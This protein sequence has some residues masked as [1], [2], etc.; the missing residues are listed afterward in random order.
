VNRTPGG[1]PPTAEQ[2]YVRR[3]GAGPRVVARSSGVGFDREEASLQA[4]VR[5]GAR[6]PGVRCPGAVFAL[7]WRESHAAVAQVADLPAGPDDP[8]PPL[9]FRFLW[10][11]R[12]DYPG[13]PFAVDRQFPADWSAAG[14]L[15][16][17]EWPAEWPAGRTVADVQS[18]L[19]AGDGP[20]LL[21]TTQALL[22]GGRV[23][24]RRPSP[25]PD[26]VRG[27]W[28]LLPASSR[29]E[30]RPATFAFSADLGFHAVALPGPPPAGYLTEE[31][32]K[33]YPEG[34]YELALQTAAEAGD[35]AELDR[36]FARKSSRDVLRLA[37]GMVLFAV[38]VAAVLRF[39]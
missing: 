9:G 37:V 12:D 19:K 15:P 6:P 13:D 21:G 32:A 31:Q 30:L 8:D 4:A 24:V 10:F 14:D 11:G 7:T 3:D 36:L 25:D 17:V 38:A 29:L 20:L 26:F 18:V 23:A 27:V 22:D 5:F 28:Q 33:D 35:Q 2:V 34:R 1:R 39:F 16:R